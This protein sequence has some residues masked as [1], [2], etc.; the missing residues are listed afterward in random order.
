MKKE[1]Y[2][3]G[4]MNENVLGSKAVIAEKTYLLNSTLN[5]VMENGLSKY[6]IWLQTTFV[7]NGKKYINP[8]VLTL[9]VK[10]SEK[11]VFVIQRY[12]RK[13]H[14]V[15]LNDNPNLIKHLAEK[16]EKCVA[17]KKEQ[18]KM[19]QEIKEKDKKAQEKETFESL[20]NSSPYLQMN[21]NSHQKMAQE[22]RERKEILKE[23]EEIFLAD[24]FDTMT[25]LSG[26]ETAIKFVKFM[27]S[28]LKNI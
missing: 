16:I 22:I 20:Y 2:Y 6:R 26:E 12:G 14:I 27:E 3:F 24:C 17:E 9:K 18:D 13:P 5:S 23:K 4:N 7:I 1:N 10:N 25:K 11:Y 19:V 21:V 15:T 28:K 8:N